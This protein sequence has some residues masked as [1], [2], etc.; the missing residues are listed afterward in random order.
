MEQRSIFGNWVPSLL[1]SAAL[2]FGLFLL[3]SSPVAAEPTAI[4]GS[5]AE[6]TRFDRDD[7]CLRDIFFTSL[8]T[9]FAVGDRGAILRTDDGGESWV[10]Q[11]SPTELSLRSITFLSPRQGWIAGCGTDES[12]GRSCG[13]V[14]GTQDGGQTWSVLCQAGIPA[15]RK[16]K[17]FSDQEGIAIGDATDRAATGVFSTADGGRTWTVIAGAAGAGWTAGEFASAGFALLAGSR[18]A[19]GSIVNGA[20]TDAQSLHSLRGFQG[21]SLDRD[22]R[23]VWFVGDGGMVVRSS[24]GG[25]TWP[26]ADNSLPPETKMVFDFK[27]VAAQRNEVWVAGSPEA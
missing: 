26:S 16:L 5:S 22:T 18:G 24:D 6:P 27:A 3:G 21:S 8:K 11:P 23:T 4:S 7:A 25:T 20:V 12:S 9:G 1:C 2:C 19:V 14:L 15:L 13:V 10:Q 17:F